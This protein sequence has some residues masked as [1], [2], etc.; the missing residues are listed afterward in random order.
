MPARIEK[1]GVISVFDFFQMFPDE[2]SAR[3]YIEK[4]RWEGGV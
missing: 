2:D 1:E 3:E 4:I